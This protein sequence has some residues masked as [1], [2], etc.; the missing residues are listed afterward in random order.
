MNI[1]SQDIIPLGQVRAKFTDL[2]EQ[3]NQGAEK[4]ITR[5]GESYVV[6]VDAKRLDFYHQLEQ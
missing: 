6:L 3:V 4:I 5:N 1:S 2:A